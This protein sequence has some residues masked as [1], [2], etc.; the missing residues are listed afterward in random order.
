MAFECLKFSKHEYI[1]FIRIIYFTLDWSS[2]YF[3]WPTLK[4]FEVQRIKIYF[5]KHDPITLTQHAHICGL[6]GAVSKF[7]M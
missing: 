4:T 6:S 1:I 7:D 3:K 2:F 5:G